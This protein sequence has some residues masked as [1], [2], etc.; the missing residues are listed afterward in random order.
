MSDIT[1]IRTS[2][3]LT[4]FYRGCSRTVLQG[5]PVFDSMI[6]ALQAGRWEEVSR[7]LLPEREIKLLSNGAIKL[8]HGQLWTYAHSE[9]QL[10][11][12]PE[13]VDW[14]F[15]AAVEKADWSDLI[16][17]V[18]SKYPHSPLTVYSTV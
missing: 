12:D 6:Q 7:T 15:R 9:W 4:V 11:E 13:V 16:K 2:N 18:Q 17:K 8:E 1:Y 3:S 5:N 10:I 14:I